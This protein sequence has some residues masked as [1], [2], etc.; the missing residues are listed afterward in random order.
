[1]C[2]QESQRGKMRCSLTRALRLSCHKGPLR[3]PAAPTQKGI[4]VT[5]LFGALGRGGESEG[6][7]RSQI[8]QP[9][10][11]SAAPVRREECSLSI[12]A[13]NL[14]Q[15]QTTWAEDVGEMFALP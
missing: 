14:G 12:S 5:E 9:G 7:H 3:L 13:L 8:G 15:S 2:G 4:Q 1:M 6:W 10:E 11:T